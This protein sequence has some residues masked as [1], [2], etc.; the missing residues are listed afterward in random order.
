MTGM[1]W[2]STAASPPACTSSLSRYGLN[3][4]YI[5]FKVLTAEVYLNVLKCV[6]LL[7][8]DFLQDFWPGLKAAHELYS[9]ISQA[10]QAK[11]SEGSQKEYVDHLP[12]EIL[13]AGI[14]SGR[15]LQ[16]QDTYLLYCLSSG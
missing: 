15:Y 13:E 8:Q 16:V 5:I 4:R 3:I 6:P 7:R 1:P 14:K 10:L 11:E 2:L 12:V 9:S